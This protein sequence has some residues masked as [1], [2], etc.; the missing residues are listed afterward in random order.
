MGHQEIS[1]YI[2]NYEAEKSLLNEDLTEEDV[3]QLRDAISLL[4]GVKLGCVAVPG[5][6]HVHNKIV[7]RVYRN[8]AFCPLLTG[9]E[10][11]VDGVWEQPV[12]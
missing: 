6:V 10:D 3:S 1:D 9:G 7:V 2:G 11:Q 8:K 4:T 12:S 5:L